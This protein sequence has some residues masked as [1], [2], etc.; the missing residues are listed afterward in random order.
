MFDLNKSN[1]YAF[2]MIIEN[3]EYILEQKKERIES[4]NYE[5]LLKQSMALFTSKF[6]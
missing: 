3:K 1:D 2:K 4:Q 6:E 5:M